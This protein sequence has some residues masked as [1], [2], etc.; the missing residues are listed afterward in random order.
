[1]KMQVYLALYG[2]VD[3]KYRFLIAQKNKKARFYGKKKFPNGINIKNGP[4]SW[5]FPGGKARP[6]KKPLCEAY[7]EFKEET[8]IDKVVIEKGEVIGI[9][10]QQYKVFFVCCSNLQD[11]VTKIKNNLRNSEFVKDDELYIALLATR[12]EALNYFQSTEEYSS[13]FI[14]AL[15]YFYNHHLGGS[16]AKAIWEI[17]DFP[18]S[19]EV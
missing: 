11:I 18:D 13:W 5:V 16:N 7:R 3:K 19:F 1:M 12:Q 14:D 15:N 17:N 2:I 6:G 4:C 8:G 10:N 9:G